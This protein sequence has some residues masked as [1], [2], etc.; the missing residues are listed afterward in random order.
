MYICVGKNGGKI[1]AIY[2]YTPYGIYSLGDNLFVDLQQN[3]YVY[4]EGNGIDKYPDGRYYKFGYSGYCDYYGDGR[5]YKLGDK[6][7]DYYSDNRYYKIGNS[8]FDYYSNGKFY[9]IGDA[10]FDYYSDGRAYKI[11]NHYIN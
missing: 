2:D 3:I 1:L 10:H 7:F 6:H 8:H 11:G 4:V 9:K 5:L